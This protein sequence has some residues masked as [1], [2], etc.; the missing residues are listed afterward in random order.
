[1]YEP[2]NAI[3][4]V[5]ELGVHVSFFLL[6]VGMGNINMKDVEGTQNALYYKV[7]MHVYFFQ[8]SVLCDFFIVLDVR[9]FSSVRS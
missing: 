9:D 7:I 3:R 2:R 5:L 4:V 1:M 6:S 8:I